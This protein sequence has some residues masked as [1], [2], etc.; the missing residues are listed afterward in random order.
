MAQRFRV[1]GRTGLNRSG[2]IIRE[3]QLKQLQ[4]SRGMKIY[5]EMRDND[6][7]IGAMLFA[8]E[9]LIKQA[10]W[11]QE[12]YHDEGAEPTPTDEE[13]ARFLRQ[14][15]ADMEHSWM[16]LI[17]EILTMLPFGWA[18]LEVCPKRRLGPDDDPKKHSQYNDGKTGLRMIELRSQESLDYWEFDDEGTVKGM[19][20]RPAPTYELLY[21]PIGRALLFRTK[22]TKNSPEGRSILRNAY[23]A[24]YYKKKFQE[25][26]GI[27]VE[28]DLAGLPKLEVPPEI[29][30]DNAPAELK[31]LYSNLQTM[32]GEIRRDEREYVIV[33]AEE[34]T[35]P[36]A[37]KPVKTGYKFSLVTSGGTRQIDI[38]RS[39]RRLR[40]D[41]ATSVLGELILLGTD[42]VGSF[43][44]A[45]EKTNLFGLVIAAILKNIAE[46]LNRQLIPMLFRWNKLD[47]TRLPHFEPGDVE[48]PSLEQLGNFLEKMGKIGFITPDP[49]L[50]RDLRRRSELPEPSESEVL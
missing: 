31:T 40:S 25:I 49:G 39:I 4:G 36:G 16:D 42:K 3:E 47:L 11:T 50:E 9:S 21:V 34:I 30:L 15:M 32:M 48:S 38:D 35:L 46:V 27:G 24:Y 29:T 14:C 22:S 18:F 20:Q 7:T 44:L 33:P 41:I 23:I 28:R 13:N 19:W 43:A 12:P 26:E 37:D 1:E 8:F 10:K 5:A 2:G 45:S 6:A 17:S